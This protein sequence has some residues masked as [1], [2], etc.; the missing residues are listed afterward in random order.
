MSYWIQSRCICSGGGGGG[1][2]PDPEAC[3]PECL[4]V[5]QVL[6]P[7]TLGYD[8]DT[9]DT[10]SFD[11][12]ALSGNS[13]QACEGSLVFE[14][15]NDSDIGGIEFIV[16]SG[17]ESILDLAGTNTPGTHVFQYKI[18]CPDKGTSAIGTVTICINS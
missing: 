2:N 5:A 8:A 9:E 18:S 15:Y 13:A 3:P 4:K 1:G 10:L 12:A 7:C 16:G 6:Y 11:L 17:G 14:N